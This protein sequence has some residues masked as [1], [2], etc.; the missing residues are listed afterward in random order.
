[1]AGEMELPEKVLQAGRRVAVASKESL[2]Q[3]LSEFL[4]TF[5][6]RPYIA[7]PATFEGAGG[8]QSEPFAC[9]VFVVE[10]GL[11]ASPTPTS[12]R[13]PVVRA[14]AVIDAYED[15]S[16]EGLQAGYRCIA[17]AK[18]LRQGARTSKSTGH[19]DE[20]LGVILAQNSSL[21]LEAIAD[22]MERLNSELPATQWPDMVAVVDTGVVQYTAQFP[23]EN[24]SGDFFLPGDTVSYTAPMYIVMVMKPAGEHTLNRM[25]SF[26]V[27]HLALFASGSEVP[28]FPAIVEGMS[29]TAVTLTGYQ[30]N[31]AG[32]VVAVPRQFY[33]DRYLA[34]L[35]F[36]IENGQGGVLGKVQFLPWQNGG[37]ILLRGEL[38]LEMLLAFLGPVA[39]KSGI[40]RRPGVQI[41]YA[42]P[43][44]EADFR[45]MLERFDRQSN[46][47]VRPDDTNW[48][49]KKFADEGSSSPFMA[50]LLLGI[51]RLRDAA[52][53]EGTERDGFDTAYQAVT[54]PLFDSRARMKKITELWEYHARRVQAG[55]IARVRGRAV[56]VDQN[57]DHDLGQETDAFLSATTRALKTGMQRVALELG[58]NIGFLFQKQAPFED[59]LDALSTQDAALAAY[60]RQTRDQW[61][62]MLV[63]RRNAIEHEG[64]RL[65]DVVYVRTGSGVRANEPH[66]DGLPITEFAAFMFDRLSCF[67]E[68]VTVHLLQRRLL[69]GITITEVPRELRAAEAPERFRV[70]L[71]VGGLPPW[72]IVYRATTFEEQ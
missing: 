20:L 7:A 26:V 25:L 52:L 3:A 61:S 8:Q 32:E 59:G 29:N 34:P 65:P 30:C 51:F 42:L 10:E 67:V 47:V 38:P 14:A 40:V 48:V 64:W 23:G 36:I 55:E 60:F 70:T 31:L 41:S 12:G 15:L 33:N 27:A 49:I 62:E 17:G 53:S 58:V 69:C 5:V 46:M 56:H 19:R 6:G 9:A 22:E 72:A 44:T 16:I 18:R 43:I 39:S 28:P 13:V 37:V 35:P 1:M 50:R 21:T 57:V 2:G 54:T 45:S 68:E 11:S 66:V 63:G 71:D 4:S 24:V